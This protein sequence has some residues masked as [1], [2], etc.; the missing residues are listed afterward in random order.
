[1]T[2]P[3]W[4]ATLIDLMLA[5]HGLPFSGGLR[6]SKPI[7]LRGGGGESPPLKVIYGG[8]EGTSFNLTS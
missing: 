5:I 2:I 3:Q 1:M 4:I 6:P 8:V 7:V